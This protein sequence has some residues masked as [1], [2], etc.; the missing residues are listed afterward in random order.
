MDPNDP[1]VEGLDLILSDEELECVVAALATF[2]PQT[3]Y[4]QAW[5]AFTTERHRRKMKAAPAPVRVARRHFEELPPAV[6]NCF[7]MKH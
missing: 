2:L 4:V 7:K 6:M 5:Q 1:G 3:L